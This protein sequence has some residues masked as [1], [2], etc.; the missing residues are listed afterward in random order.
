MSVKG[1][2]KLMVESGKAAP[3][4]AIGQALGPLG[5]NMAQFCKDFNERTGNMIEGVPTPTDLVA[6]QNRTYEFVSYFSF[7]VFA[8]ALHCV[9]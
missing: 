5:L 8:L 7:R 2:V 3:S 9:S 6:F 4:P 1:F